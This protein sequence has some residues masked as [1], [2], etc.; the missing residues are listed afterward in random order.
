LSSLS[1]PSSPP[2]SFCGDHNQVN[3]RRRRR[4]H[5]SADLQV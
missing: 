5:L 2:F 3:S 1:L 4:T